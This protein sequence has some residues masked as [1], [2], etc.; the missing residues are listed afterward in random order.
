MP[1]APE[2]IARVR[3]APPRRAKHNRRRAPLCAPSSEQIWLREAAS[4][5]NDC[6]GLSAFSSSSWRPPPSS[7][8]QWPPRPRRGLP[9]QPSAESQQTDLPEARHRKGKMLW[10]PSGTN[11]QGGPHWSSCTRSGMAQS[12]L[13]SSTRR[14]WIQNDGSSKRVSSYNTPIRLKRL[15][16]ETRRDPKPTSSPV[17]PPRC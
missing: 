4:D 3:H 14:S 8:A 16:K 1:R 11:R 6:C 10:Q 13:D 15:H 17:H 7:G 9:G 2:R 5:E 12:H